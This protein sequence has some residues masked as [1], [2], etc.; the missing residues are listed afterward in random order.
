MPRTSLR[1]Q[2]CH[3]PSLLLR[4]RLR[5]LHYSLRS[6][7]SFVAVGASPYSPPPSS[8][9]RANFYQCLPYGRVAFC[10]NSILPTRKIYHGHFRSEKG[11]RSDTILVYL[12]AKRHFLVLL[13]YSIEWTDILIELGL[14][15]IP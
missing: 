15:K 7:L 13:L 8:V 2:T 11:V 3:P 4:R 1:V 9:P 6:Q 5:N 10:N 14:Q 12:R